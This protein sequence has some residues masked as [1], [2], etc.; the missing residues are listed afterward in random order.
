MNGL[1]N[2]QVVENRE[3]YG[4]NKLP[5]PKLKKWY[6]FAKDALCEKITMILI[7]IA[8]L[9]MVLGFLGVMELSEPLM[10]MFVLAIVT[11]IAV[12]TGLG[13]QKSAAELRAKTSI[14]HC[15][16]IRNGQLQTIN[17]D[18]LVVGDV[19]CVGMGQEIF[20]DGYL[21]EIVRNIIEREYEFKCLNNYTLPFVLRK[22][23]REEITENDKVFYHEGLLSKF[24]EVPNME[25]KLNENKY[26]V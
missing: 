1:T 17:K 6:H 23:N 16:V 25:V 18:E 7:A 3:K 5:E 26:S 8:M 19:V 4:S 21:M 10:I 2:E 14:R 12:K 11:C 13:V 9:Q 20:A 24:M 15:D 22:F